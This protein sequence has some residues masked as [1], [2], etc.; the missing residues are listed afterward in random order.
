M[1]SLAR[2]LDEYPEYN[3]RLPLNSLYDYFVSSPAI[4]GLLVCLARM[5]LGIRL[6]DIDL[7]LFIVLMAAG[8]LLWP[9]IMIVR[10]SNGIWPSKRAMN[11]NLAWNMF[12]GLTAGSMWALSPLR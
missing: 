4:A 7:V 11:V 3:T 2:N 6:G 5:F 10:L 9:I 8:F 1:R 12:S